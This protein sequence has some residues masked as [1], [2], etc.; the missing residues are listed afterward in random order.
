MN[1]SRDPRLFFSRA[2][3]LQKPEKDLNFEARQGANMKDPPISRL[4]RMEHE[5]K[6]IASLDISSNETIPAMHLLS[7]M[8]AGMPSGKKIG[9]DENARLSKQP[10]SPCRYH[11]KE[12]CGLNLG[13]CKTCIPLRRQ[14]FDS[15]HQAKVLPGKY[16]E[17]SAAPGFS[18]SAPLSG[19]ANVF[20]SGSVGKPRVPLDVNE[21]GKGKCFEAGISGVAPSLAVNVGLGTSYGFKPYHNMERNS[22]NSLGAR[23]I[24]QQMSERQTIEAPSEIRTAI[25]PLR[26]N[27]EAAICTVNRNPA[28]FSVPE[29]GNIYSIGRDDLKLTKRVVR[30]KPELSN[31]RC[32]GGK[33]MAKLKHT[34][35]TSQNQPQTA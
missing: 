8:D 21:K 17:L 5:E 12:V 7:L 30:N 13:L 10:S 26:N 25:L 16:Q 4:K 33:K 1:C 22:P 31:A 27:S 24:S 28:E 32:R 20:S 3:G 9:L 2:S 23:V 14:S 34:A 18:L 11:A 19:P 29:E 35:G 6:R 15:D